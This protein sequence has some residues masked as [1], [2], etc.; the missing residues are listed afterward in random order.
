MPAMV[1]SWKR[2][3]SGACCAAAYEAGTVSAAQARSIPVRCRISALQFIGG[4]KET[5]G[6][7]RRVCKIGYENLAAREDGRRDFAHA[8]GG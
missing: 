1:A 5:F 7:D 8:V 2:N 3:E 4:P 6:Q